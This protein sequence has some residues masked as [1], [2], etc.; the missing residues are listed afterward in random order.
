MKLYLACGLELLVHA[1]TTR[2]WLQNRWRTDEQLS[3][4]LYL[5]FKALSKAR[6]RPF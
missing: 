2:A 1:V 6:W 3:V 5:Y 4:V